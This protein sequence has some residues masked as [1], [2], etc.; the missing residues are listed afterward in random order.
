MA[1]K[2]HANP[3][4]IEVIAGFPLRKS[5]L[6]AFK[7]KRSRVSA[8][9]DGVSEIAGIQGVGADEKCALRELEKREQQGQHFPRL[10]LSRQNVFPLRPGPDREQ[11]A[12]DSYRSVDVERAW[13]DIVNVGFPGEPQ[14][15]VDSRQKLGQ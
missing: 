5:V 4:S 9:L 1:R 2:H 12:D 14:N 3:Y 8:R 10:C 6:V 7:R 15:A 11:R 13:H